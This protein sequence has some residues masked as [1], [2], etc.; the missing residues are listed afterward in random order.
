M[1]ELE[2][3]E[4]RFMSNSFYLSNSAV[5]NR[6]PSTGM[7]R[8]IMAGLLI[9]LVPFF[10]IAY[11][12]YRIN[13]GITMRLPVKISYSEHKSA[14]NIFPQIKLSTPLNTISTANV[15]GQN[16][17]LAEDNVF[18]FLSP[19]PDNIWYPY[20]VSK[21]PPEQGCQV[22]ECLVLSGEI[23]EAQ[24]GTIQIH[25]QFEDFVPSDQ[26]LQMIRYKMPRHSEITLV[27]GK[28]GR[29]AVRSLHL[30]GQTLNQRKMDMPALFGFIQSIASKAP[31][32]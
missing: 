2:N 7:W 15:A 6:A 14:L 25:Y 27:I 26:I 21:R 28:D 1:A 10:A 18:V 3:K 13:Y 16:V 5:P 22:D 32:K 12:S 9:L 19:G 4:S 29:A 23:A 8:Y 31:L 30:D 17:F 20:A 11:Q 24:S